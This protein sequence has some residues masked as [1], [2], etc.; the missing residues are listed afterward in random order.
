MKIISRE[1]AKEHGLKRY[2]TGEPC[3]HGHLSERRTGDGKCVA[4][5]KIRTDRYYQENR[6]AIIERNRLYREDNYEKCRE[7]RLKYYY[8]NRER[9]L[10]EK[11][12]YTSENRDIIRERQRKWREENPERI[13][14]L[15]RKWREENPDKVSDSYKRWYQ[16]NRE[17]K[18][19]QNREWY[20][21]NREAYNE[22]VRKRYNNNPDVKLATFIRG[23]LRKTLNEEKDAPSFEIV[24]YTPQEL[25]EHIESQFIEGMTWENHGEW[26]IDHIVPISYMIHQGETDPAVINALSNLQPMW[27]EENLSKGAK[28]DPPED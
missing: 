11:R 19:A 12:K 1:E 13:K 5:V 3:R 7:T 2:F 20:E 24:G 27:A 21:N 9:L 17:R 15:W 23:C 10:E 14:E 6:E 25:R 18:L 8:D 16:E 28:Y 26:H 22:A 4:C